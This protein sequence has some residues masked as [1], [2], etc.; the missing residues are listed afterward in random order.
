MPL[1]KEISFS[2]EGE[3]VVPPLPEAV[4]RKRKPSEEDS[5][6]FGPQWSGTFRLRWP[7]IADTIQI[8]AQVTAYLEGLGVQSPSQVPIMA[9][10]LV[11]SLIF[12]EVLALDKPTWFTREAADTAEAETAFVRAFQ[13]A[14]MKM[15]EAKKKADENGGAT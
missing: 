5:R 9:Y 2:L 12:F 15:E 6:V 3:P 11:H 4:K 7:T 10:Q 8:P 13:I 1:P 14:T